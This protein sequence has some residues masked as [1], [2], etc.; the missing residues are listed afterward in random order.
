MIILSAVYND[1]ITEDEMV[2]N[3]KGHIHEHG[4]DDSKIL[5]E[6]LVDK[7]QPIMNR[8]PHMKQLE[9]FLDDIHGLNEKSCEVSIF[10]KVN[11]E[12]EEVLLL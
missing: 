6:I 5:R 3:T 12:T 1:T 7:M 4:D 2:S 11:E 8:K 9:A 10:P